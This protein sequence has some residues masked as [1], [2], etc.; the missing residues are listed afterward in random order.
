M[1]NERPAMWIDETPLYN[2]ETIDLIREQGALPQLVQ[3]WILNKA[4]GHINIEKEF[5][6]KLLK[7][8]RSNNQLTSKESF[9]DHLHKR[10]INE[11]QLIKILIRPYQVIQYREDR[12]GPFAESLYLQNKEKFDSITYKR[13]E[14]SN[15]EVMQEIYFRLKD[16]EEGWDEL[17]RQFPG[18][19]PDATAVRGPIPVG[20]VEVPIL[21]ALRQSKP[22]R[23]PRPLQVGNQ[24]VVVS[25]D[26]FQPSTFGEDVRNALLKTAFEEWISQECSKMLNKI[27]FPQ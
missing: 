23:I 24:I 17:A 12:W 13:L 4:V 18:A 15:S 8:Y 16:G 6:D 3:N 21:E 11:T 2:Q 20:E 1:I 26:R 25:L 19:P 14:S 9:A 7:D 22:G 27:R 5:K 10:H